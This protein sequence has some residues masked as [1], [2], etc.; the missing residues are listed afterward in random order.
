MGAVTD[1]KTADHKDLRVRE[2]FRWILARLMHDAV[3]LLEKQ[4]RY[5]QAAACLRL[6]LSTAF[7]PGKRG[8]WWNRL[9]LN[10]EHLGRKKHALLLAETALRCDQNLRLCDQLILQKRVF[11][12]AKP[13]LRWGKPSFPLSPLPPMTRSPSPLLPTFSITSLKQPRATIIRARLIREH[14]RIGVQPNC[15]SI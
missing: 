11:K 2:I 13:P 14:V 6:L 8:H 7:C 10:I 5:D 3:P 4:K 1:L 15:Q 9:S 12:L